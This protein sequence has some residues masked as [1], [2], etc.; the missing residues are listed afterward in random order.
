MMLDQLSGE[1]TP[2]LALVVYERSS[3][4]SS[5][6]SH[7]LEAFDFVHDPKSS[8]YVLGSGRPVTRVTLDELTKFLSKRSK[9]QKKQKKEQKI[10]TFRSKR[11]P[12]NVL[13]VKQVGKYSKIAFSMNRPVRNMLFHHKLNLPNGEV[14]LPNLLFIYNQGVKV[15]AYKDD[16]LT[17][18]TRLFR[19]PFHN[20]TETGVCM[21]SAK[22]KFNYDHWENL[23]DAVDHAFFN[24]YF[25]HLHGGNPVDGNLNVIYHQCISEN[26]EFPLDLLLPVSKK[27]KDVL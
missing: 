6:P 20:T 27:L 26:K 9:Q 23:V 1:Y 2:Q 14:K 17:D 25:T 12:N 15:F 24:S 8:H 11:I 22:V 13:T 4:D 10:I 3:D 21:G 19:A 16:E 18:D 7:Q 5:L